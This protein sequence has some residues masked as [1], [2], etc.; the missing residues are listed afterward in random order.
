[1]NHIMIP[2][3][4]H[5]S[6]LQNKKNIKIRIAE[7]YQNSNK[8][9]FCH[10]LL[11]S[12]SLS[13]IILFLCSYPFTYQ[14]HSLCF[15]SMN[16]VEISFFPVP[17]V[18]PSPKPQEATLSYIQS[19][20]VCWGIGN[21]SECIQWSLSIPQTQEKPSLKHHWHHNIW[22]YQIPLYGIA[23]IINMILSMWRLSR[24]Y[25][26]VFKLCPFT[27]L[28]VVPEHLLWSPAQNLIGTKVFLNFHL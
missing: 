19:V 18:I 27:Q 14:D 1:M 21:F 23:V 8:N 17:S 9:I 5:Y 26:D 4:T 2:Y 6:V 10:A 7:Y 20:T 11:N 15:N 25:Y 16:E 28:K 24:K 3:Q 22:S 12:L 13:P